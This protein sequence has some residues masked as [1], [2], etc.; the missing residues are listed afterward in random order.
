[1]NQIGIDS[2]HV[3]STFL[4][5]FDL[6]GTF[7]FALSGLSEGSDRATQNEQQRM[8]GGITWL[9]RFSYVGVSS[10]ASRTS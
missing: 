1:M 3:V 7:I 4:I 8:E 10:T 2:H 6:T 5:V 9:Q